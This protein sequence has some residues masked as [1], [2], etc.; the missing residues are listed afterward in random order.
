MIFCV[1]AHHIGKVSKAISKQYE[2][3]HTT[4][5]TSG[6]NSRQ[7]FSRVN[8]PTGSDCGM[9][10]DFAKNNHELDLRLYRPQLAC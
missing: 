6:K 7:V 3:C 8:I 4:V 5:F 10:R 2:V 1:A 9:L